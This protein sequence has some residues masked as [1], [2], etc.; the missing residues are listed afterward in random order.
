LT[1]KAVKLWQRGLNEREKN[2]G[3]KG[4]LQGNR[5]DIVKKPLGSPWKR[6]PRAAGGAARGRHPGDVGPSGGNLA[7]REAFLRGGAGVH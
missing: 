5:I 4:S 1:K 6:P 2:C 7:A 3:G